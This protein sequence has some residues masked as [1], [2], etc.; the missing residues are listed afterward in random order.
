M[1]VLY[2]SIFFRIRY[3]QYRNEEN[4][5]VARPLAALY[6]A[7]GSELNEIYNL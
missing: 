4:E 5:E 1:V 3:S 7:V 2:G 6:S